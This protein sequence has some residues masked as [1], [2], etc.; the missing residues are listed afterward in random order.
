[1]TDLHTHLLYGIDDGAADMEM[2]VNML[3]AML[4]DGVKTVV[5]TPHFNYTNVPPEEF[6]SKR[7][8]V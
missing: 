8:S 3:K 2:S 6:I 4:R 5:A 7:D 1:M